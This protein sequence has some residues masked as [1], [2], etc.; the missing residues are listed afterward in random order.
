[1]TALALLTAPGTASGATTPPAGG[2]MRALATDGP[3][4]RLVSVGGAERPYLL[5]RP[6]GRVLGA[7]MV[8][9]GQNQTM[10]QAQQSYGLG[11]LS[12]RGQLV[13]YLGGYRGSWNAGTCCG[14]A[15]AEGR[16]DIG[17]V[18][19]VMA[20]LATLLPA[21]RPTALLGVSSGAMLAYTVVCHGRLDLR[22]VLSVS[23]T[24]A[25]GC[26]SSSV[27][28]PYRFLEL[29]GSRDTTIP[30]NPP[31]RRS[32]LL[33]MAPIPT[34]PAVDTLVSAA[35]CPRRVPHGAARTDWGGCAGGGVV[36]LLVKPVGHSYADLGPPVVLAR[37]LEEIGATSG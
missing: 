36:R 6:A 37:A 31:S 12:Q 13:A 33:G 21:G 11:F 30:L 32:A 2:E 19:A 23:G 28:L 29:H 9:H 35:Q 5:V 20:D 7:V 18:R 16:D 1:M 34:R 14:A 8:A 25:A 10:G 17:Y 15:R 4:R 27:R 22:L 26:P 3:E 24:R